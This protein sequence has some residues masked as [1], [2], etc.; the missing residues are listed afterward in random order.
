MPKDFKEYKKNRR[1]TDA[2][3]EAGKIQ[4]AL[5]LTVIQ[6]GNGDNKEYEGHLAVNDVLNKIDA[7][8][9]MFE[10]SIQ[11]NNF[12]E[13]SGKITEIICNL[14][15]L[16][17]IKMAEAKKQAKSYMEK[18]TGIPVSTDNGPEEIT[19]DIED[20]EDVED[21]EEKP[22]NSE[23]ETMFKTRRPMQ[24]PEEELEPSDKEAMPP[25]PI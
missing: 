21:I 22:G 9:R 12:Q 11:D 5:A 3:T 8:I 24:P 16:A 7:M 17:Q 13:S 18:A 2:Y 6:A 25:E 19:D 15:D 4:E 14:Y 10:R 20:I 1:L 23:R